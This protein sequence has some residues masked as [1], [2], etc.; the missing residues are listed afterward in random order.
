VVVHVSYLRP[1]N[2]SKWNEVPRHI[3]IY[4]P[5]AFN[6]DH[7]KFPEGA[8][9]RILHFSE[10]GEQVLISWGFKSKFFSESYDENDNPHRNTFYVPVQYVRMAFID[11]DRGRVRAPWP[12]GSLRNKAPKKAGDICTVAGRS[13]T[14]IDKKDHEKVLPAD[15]VVKLLSNEGG[16]SRTRNWLCEILGGCDDSLI[17][18]QLYIQQ[19]YMKSHP[20]PESLY[21]PG[22][23]VEIVA[24]VDFRK[25]PLKGMRGKV[26]L[27]TDEDG[28]VGIE[29][30]EDIGA[31]SLDGAGKEGH[32]IYL[33]AHAMKASE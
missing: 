29:F 3:G 15:T 2:E 24:K 10:D 5:E 18:V 23:Q 4:V 26:I 22:Q 25:T 12:A 19:R 9:G 8:V 33:E 6:Y 31:G 17:G 7:A 30:P 16:S 1:A 27:M 28:D 14:C 11:L 13:V 20:D 21:L 32:C